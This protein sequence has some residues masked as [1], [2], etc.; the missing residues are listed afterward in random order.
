MLEANAAMKSIVRGDSGEG[1]RQ[2]IKRLAQEAGIEDPTEEDARRLDRKR[3]KRVSN[4]DWE[5][6]TD[7]ASR[8][9]K[10][11]DGRIHLAYKARRADR[12]A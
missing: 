12:R 11:K 6:N 1:W 2:Y 3:K 7:P 10:M 5:S 9:M 4:K 8:I